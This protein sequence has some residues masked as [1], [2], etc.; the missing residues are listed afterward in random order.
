MKNKF[1]VQISLHGKLKGIAIFLCYC[2]YAD[3][4]LKFK[5]KKWGKT[6]SNI[7][8]EHYLIKVVFSFNENWKINLTRHL[9]YH[10]FFFFN[11][12]NTEI[13]IP[14]NLE[15]CINKKFTIQ[16]VHS[17]L[18]PKMIPCHQINDIFGM[19]STRSLLFSI[20]LTR[21]HIR[22]FHIY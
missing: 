11:I 6:Q 10:L 7:E 12:G 22:E 16:K 18:I 15:G 13:W 14:S 8:V 17:Y 4:T 21:D 3:I 20:L 9:I 19:W 5:Q 1:T 2:I